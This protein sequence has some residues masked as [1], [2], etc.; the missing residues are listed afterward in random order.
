MVVE[1]AVLV[2]VEYGE[3]EERRRLSLAGVADARRG[4]SWTVQ[5]QRGWEVTYDIVNL[6]SLPLV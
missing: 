2:Y 4:A 3:L 1:A 5:I 6:I